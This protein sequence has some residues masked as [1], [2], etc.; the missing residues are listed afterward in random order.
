[1]IITISRGPFCVDVLSLAKGQGPDLLVLRTHSFTQEQLLTHY[2]SNS[3]SITRTTSIV[4]EAPFTMQLLFNNENVTI[5]HIST[6]TTVQRNNSTTHRGIS[7]ISVIT[8][9]KYTMQTREPYQIRPDNHLPHSE[10]PQPSHENRP[11]PLSIYAS[12]A[13][14]RTLSRTQ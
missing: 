5:N 1:M 11:C 14:Y 9:H 10:T 2:L 3:S 7:G 13:S 12:S 4:H 6:Q 8:N